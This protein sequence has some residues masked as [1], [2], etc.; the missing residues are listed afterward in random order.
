M[1]RQFNKR[2]ASVFGLRTFFM[3]WAFLLFMS[4][5]REVTGGRT[6]EVRGNGGLGQNPPQTPTCT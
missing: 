2:N 4:I 6:S 1:Q 5:V 3:L